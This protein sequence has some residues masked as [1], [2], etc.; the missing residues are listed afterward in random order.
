MAG[1]KKIVLLLLLILPFI[2]KGQAYASTSVHVESTGDSHAQVKIQNSFET[3]STSNT[4]VHTK[5]RIESNGEVKT[6]ESDKAEDINIQS[7][8]GNSKVEIK[9]GETAPDTKD[10]KLDDQK[11]ETEKEIEQTKEKPQKATEDSDKNFIE[12]VVDFFKGIFGFGE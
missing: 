9:N 12:I 10:E 5:I 7:T 3:T 6:Y 1:Y 11:K 8:D 4:D 2:P